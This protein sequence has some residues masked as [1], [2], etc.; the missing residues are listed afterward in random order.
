MSEPGPTNSARVEHAG[1]QAGEDF[2][3]RRGLRRRAEPA[4]DFAAEAERADFQALRSARAFELAA[5]PAAHADAGIAAHERLHAERRV[6]LVPQRLSAAGIDPGDMLVRRQPERHRGE[7]GR[8]RLLALPVERRGVAHLGD[9]GADRVEHL[10]SRHHLARGGPRSQAARRRAR[11]AL[12]DALGRHAGPRQALRPR[13][14]HAPAL[15]LRARDRRRGERARRA[16]GA[17]AERAC[18]A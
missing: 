8:R 13:R 17:A 2:G 11:D 18:G 12:G 9:A 14:H 5:E 6:E 3:R 7:E 10:E 4:I 16:R 15:R 1:L